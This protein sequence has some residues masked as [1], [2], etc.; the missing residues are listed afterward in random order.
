MCCSMYVSRY[1]LHCSN[2]L[3]FVSPKASKSRLTSRSAKQKENRIFADRFLHTHPK[4]L[5][6]LVLSKMKVFINMKFWKCVLSSKYST[7][8]DED[9]LLFSLHPLDDFV[10]ALGESSSWCVWAGY[11]VEF[12]EGGCPCQGDAVAVYAVQNFEVVVFCV[13]GCVEVVIECH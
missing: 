3:F 4:R 9:T 13:C 7:S 2:R 5:D 1:I 8:N 6:D 11:A 12:E 10:C